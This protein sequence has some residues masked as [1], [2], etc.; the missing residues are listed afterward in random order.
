MPRVRC[1]VHADAGAG[2]P[3]EKS[4][5]DKCDG[6]QGT[7]PGERAGAGAEARSVRCGPWGKLRTSAT[8]PEMDWPRLPH[9]IGLLFR[10][11]SRKAPNDLCAAFDALAGCNLEQLR[12]WYEPLLEGE[13][14]GAVAEVLRLRPDQAPAALLHGG[15]RGLPS[16]DRFLESGY[17]RMMA[18]RYVL[19]GAWLCRGRDVL[20]ACCGLG[21]GA[22][23]VS[24]YA[25][26]VTA[27]DS[28]S[29]SVKFAAASWPAS[30]IRWLCGDALDSGWLAAESFD[31]VLAMEAVEHFTAAD[32]ERFV[33]QMAARLRKGGVFAGTS[34]FPASAGEAERLA[35][36]NPHHPH[37]FTEQEFLALLRRHFRRAAVAGNWMFLALR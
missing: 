31:V 14:A 5:S 33:A 1:P 11:R 22:Y 37:I 36:Q 13:A 21:W 32:G 16:E 35:A 25:R 9:P 34:A 17:W 7:S 30:N 20:D 29:G 18:G 3:G 27:F 6:R 2:R 23:L 8:I 28:D 26:T 12:A 10:R 19:A 24:Q 15:E 4:A